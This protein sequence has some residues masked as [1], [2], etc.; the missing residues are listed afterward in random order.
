M[1][2]CLLAYN[3]VGQDWGPRTPLDLAVSQDN[4]QTWK[5]IAHLEDDPDQESEYSY[6]AIVKTTGGIAISYTWNRS[7]IRCWQVPESLLTV[8]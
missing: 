4:G 5:T 3:P 6:P 2:E 7:N 8:D 1:G